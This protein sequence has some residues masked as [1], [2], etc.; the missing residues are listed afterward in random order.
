CS[1]GA[2]RVRLR[3]AARP[4]TAARDGPDIPRPARRGSRRR[5]ASP[6]PSRRAARSLR[7]PPRK[8]RPPVGPR[9]RCRRFRVARTQHAADGCRQRIAGVES[10]GDRDPEHQGDHPAHLLLLGAPG[11][12]HGLLDDAGSVAAY[13]DARLRG[14]EDGNSS[15]LAEDQRGARVLRVEDVLEG[16]DLRTVEEQLPGEPFMKRAQPILDRAAFSYLEDAVRE[17]AH[18]GAAGVLDDAKAA[19]PRTGIDPQ[20]LHKTLD[21][22]AAIS[23]SGIS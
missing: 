3:A 19:V 22:I 10:G 18:A 9:P 5:R 13:R 16:N 7:K 4:W 17:V 15:G 12:G 21:S 1:S 2:A 23:S 8:R 14:G 20:D 6:A 11:P